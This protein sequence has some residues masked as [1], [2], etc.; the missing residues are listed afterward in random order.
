MTIINGYCTLSEF[1]SYA[2]PNAGTNAADDA[3][4]EDI[5]EGQSRRVDGICKRVFYQVTESRYFVSNDGM[6]LFTG[7]IATTTGLVIYSGLNSDNTYQDTWASTDYDLM[8]YT[9]VTGWPYT[10]IDVNRNG[11]YFFSRYSKG[12]KVTATWGWPS[13]PDAIKQA[14]LIMA[15]NEY[16][17]RNGENTSTEARVTSIGVVLTPSGIPKQALELLQPYIKIY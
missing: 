2:I 12:N 17:N 3:V 11:S 8:P 4:I 7:D 6:S 1:K 10:W 16:N 5:I 14:C 9:P 13:V 15:R